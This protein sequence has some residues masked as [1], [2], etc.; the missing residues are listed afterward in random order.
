MESPRHWYCL[1][2]ELLIKAIEG[3]LSFRI[4]HP[5]LHRSRST[6]QNIVLQ[7]QINEFSG[8][9]ESDIVCT[10]DNPWSFCLNILLDGTQIEQWQFSFNIIDKHPFTDIYTQA[11]VA[12]RSILVLAQILPGF[13][14]FR[15]RKL[16]TYS[17]RE[18]SDWS[19]HQKDKYRLTLLKCPAG[20]L[21]VEVKYNRTPEVLPLPRVPGIH[22]A[23]TPPAIEWACISTPASPELRSISPPYSPLGENILDDSIE[24]LPEFLLDPKPNE[25]FEGKKRRENYDCSLDAECQNIMKNIDSILQEIQETEEVLKNYYYFLGMFYKD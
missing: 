20:S 22:G 14:L 12:L 15:K 24:I 13:A 16:I 18:A 7:T 25:K 21:Y 11:S 23:S 17:L 1:L 6:D 10:I 9:R 3:I 2:G 4:F 5:E 8:I 19:H